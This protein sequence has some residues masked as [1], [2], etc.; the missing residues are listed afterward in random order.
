MTNHHRHT[1]STYNR[2]SKSPKGINVNQTA[3]QSCHNMSI[4]KINSIK[5][6]FHAFKAI[7]FKFLTLTYGSVTIWIS[8]VKGVAK[9]TRYLFA[10]TTCLT[11]LKWITNTFLYLLLFIALPWRIYVMP[12]FTGP[13]LEPETISWSNCFKTSFLWTESIQIRRYNFYFI[14]ITNLFYISK[15]TKYTSQYCFVNRVSRTERADVH[16]RQCF[17]YARD[18]H[19]QHLPNLIKRL[20]TNLLR[21]VK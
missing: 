7:L 21:S 10:D 14:F 9:S 11:A 5:E 3:I 15:N 1:N 8:R 20:V 16:H 17:V 13:K 4:L 12:N 19:Y 18:V 2:L 6:I